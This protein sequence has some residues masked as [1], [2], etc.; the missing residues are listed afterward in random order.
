MVDYN[1]NVKIDPNR[2]EQGSKRVN[3][4]LES[5]EKRAKRLE[6]LFTKVFGGIAIAAGVRASIRLLR[7]YSQEM[8][9]MRAI[10]G[11]TQTQFESLNEKA[12]QLGITT[13]FSA[14]EAA[15][16]MTFLARAGFSV[17][18]TLDTI[19]P[20]LQLAQ[21]G[22]LGLAR[23]ADIA[24][25][26][27]K[28]F[29]LETDQSG[30]VVDVLAKAANSANTDV[31]QLGQALSFVAP[32]A[33]G[34]NISLE[35]TVAA[36][37]ALSD[38]GIQGSRAGTGLSR[39]LAEL[40]SPAD[41]TRQ[42]FAA[43]G[44]D[45]AKVKPSTVGLTAAL[46]ELESAG[47]STGT[48]LE[49]FGQRGGP[50]F[51]VLAASIGDIETLEEKL[52]NAGGTAERVAAIMDDNLNG[53]AL[54]FRSALEGLV[55]ELGDSGVTGALKAL[56]AY[57]TIGIRKLAEH[58]DEIIDVF[59]GFAAVLSIRLARQA[60]PAAIRSIRML[61]I[62]I[63]A[64]PIGAI[65]VVLAV[66][67][68]LLIG[69]ADKIGLG[70]DRLSNLKELGVA[71]FQEL[72]SSFEGFINFFYENFGFIGEYAQKV[73]GDINL[74]VEGV[75]R[76]GAKTVDNYLGLW[77]G[78]YKALLALFE[79]FGPALKS[80]FVSALNGAILV[81]EY[82]IHEISDALNVL[83]R[84]VLAPTIPMAKL[85]RII[86][87]NAGA[88]G[89]MAENIKAGF[90][91]GFNQVDIVESF[92]DRV[93]D[94]AE[95]MARTRIANAIAEEAAAANDNKPA[96]GGSG[97]VDAAALLLAQ[98]RQAI[99]DQTVS[100]LEREGAALR[101]LGDER[102]VYQKQLE[103]EDQIAQKLR[104]SSLNLTE[105]Q[106]NRM[107]K[108]N[109]AE[110]ENIARLVEQ[111]LELERQAAILD[112]LRGPGI[113][114]EQTLGSLNKLL[115]AGKINLQEF[116]VELNNTRL[117]QELSRLDQSLGGD[118][119]H[120]DDM[121]RIQAQGEER[122]LLVQQLQDQNILNETEAAE[123]IIAIHEDM[124]QRI[125][126]IEVARQSLA[127]S[128]ASDMFGSLA[129]ATK[130]FAGEQ[131]GIYKA[132]F[133]VSKAFAIAD[134]IVKIQQGIANAMSLPFPANIAAAATVA[135]Q[136]ASIVSTISSV[137][138]KFA[139]GGQVHG[140][141][142]G[143]SDSIVARL[144]DG[145]Y[146]INAAATRKHLPLLEAINDNKYATGGYVSNSRPPPIADAMSGQPGGGAI[147][148][149]VG[150]IHVT[151]KGGENPEE[152][153][154]KAGRT[155]AKEFEAAVV[156]ILRKHQ[157]G[158]GV[159]VA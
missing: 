13:R 63:A 7:D 154:R 5:M 62:A 135:A 130:S 18:E 149:S 12:K 83:L 78:F 26:V 66:A 34:L 91:E 96:G 144:S 126:N 142:T 32:V 1:I 99:I 61:T 8:S 24:S 123:R 85:G 51:A 74:S 52:D 31:E 84:T 41:K 90:I 158:Q 80:I 35:Q 118:I 79:G 45:I 98:E 17:Q 76:F 65:I 146:V 72:G 49:I 110:A 6:R 107:S 106:I 86:D 133:A 103:I 16:G 47:I 43:M 58:T 4:S 40:E 152:A 67:T 121:A 105:E 97:E 104:E 77:V 73:F 48:A 25:N 9:T 27:L 88:A 81:V 102:T 125:T 68:A 92:L 150:D 38:A 100:S 151:V 138:A 37:G 114:Y 112:N 108:L 53:A 64:N 101:L 75:L 143:T 157:R 71:A 3:K 159:L 115:A 28:G 23:S 50:A 113:S 36:I 95:D 124:N 117:M 39:V 87:K 82:G 127:I 54:A 22:N 148:I 2:A 59:Q 147:T 129:D 69:F 21:A 155:A 94:R 11:A 60:I 153:G 140:P 46:K 42:I 122:L 111:N 19:G 109:T 29:R 119:A 55:I 10:T 89:R 137:T 30:R 57:M 131:S 134:S 44:V 15:A 141:G 93:I 14:R 33:A 20:T 145:E 132:M 136:A 56:F 156:T 120:A 116:N 128:S 139:E 70:G